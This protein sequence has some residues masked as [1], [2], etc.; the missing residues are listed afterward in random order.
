MCR[1]GRPPTPPLRAVH[2]SPLRRGIRA[3]GSFNRI[4][5]SFTGNSV[6]GPYDRSWACFLVMSNPR[7]LQMHA[8]ATEAATGATTTLVR[9]DARP[10][11]E[12]SSDL[13]PQL[14][15]QL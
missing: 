6:G 10:R 2:P 15:A 12:D 14:R 9:A 8:A 3:Q 11:G 5:R 1:P 4:G 13:H 7:I